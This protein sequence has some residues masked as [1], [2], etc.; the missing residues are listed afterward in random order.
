MNLR[1][2]KLLILGANPETVPLVEAS[3]KMGIKTFVTDNNPQAIAKKHADKSFDIDGLNVRELIK[4]VKNERID[5]ILVGVADRLIKPYQEICDALKLPCYATAEQCSILTNKKRFN[6]KCKEFQINPIP[7]YSFEDKTEDLKI[8]DV[9]FPIFLKPV[10]GNSGKGMSICDEKKEIPVAIEKAKRESRSRQFLVE[11]YMDCDDIL[12][13]FTFKDGEVYLSAIADRFTCRKQGKV[14]RVCLGATYPSKYQ[15]LYYKTLHQNLCR[16]F[17]NLKIKNGVL[18]ISGF[19][20]NN[21]IFVYD[22]G[23]RLQG[24]A[25]DIHIQNVNGFDQKE[26][27]IRQALSGSMGNDDLQKLNDPTFRGKHAATVWFLGRQGKISRISGLDVAQNDRSVI[28]VLERMKEGDL[29]EREMIGTEAQ[30]LFRLYLVAQTKS[31][32][33]EKIAFFQK[34]IKAYDDKNSQIILNGFIP[35]NKI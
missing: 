13:Y 23:F 27:L 34:T 19:V 14:S 30:V 6:E 17:R 26:M 22:P 31:E 9:Q 35:E 3:K 21:K 29:I 5:G 24:E 32:I 2:K 7:S 20:E 15:D 18:L 12:M 8:R 1:N 33:C 25:A 4:T 10:D 16:M 28:A 11:R